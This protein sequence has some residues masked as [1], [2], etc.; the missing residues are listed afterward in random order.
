MRPVLEGQTYVPLGL[1]P[2]LPRR[3]VRSVMAGLD[4]ACSLGWAKDVRPAIVVGLYPVFASRL[5]VNCAF[6]P[7]DA[8]P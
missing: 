5:R 1:D 4:S 3:R 8:L 2:L 7:G 6:V